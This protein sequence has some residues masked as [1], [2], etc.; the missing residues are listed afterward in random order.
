MRLWGYVFL[1]I[2]WLL[3]PLRLNQTQA[4]PISPPFQ[5]LDKPCLY[6]YNMSHGWEKSQSALNL[7]RYEVP[8]TRQF[9]VVWRLQ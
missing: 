2:Y 5:K 4:T 8:V 1:S 7:I 3:S 9:R 6:V